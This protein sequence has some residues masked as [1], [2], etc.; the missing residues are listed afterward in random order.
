MFLLTSVLALGVIVSSTAVQAEDKDDKKASIKGVMKSAHGEAGIRAK[1]KKGVAAK[2]WDDVEA[3]AKDWV[4]QAEALGKL[5]PPKGE[6]ESWKKLTDAYEKN[7]K[8]VAA[9]ATKKDAKAVNTAMGKIGTSCG[10]CHKAHK[11]K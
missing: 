5:T 2:E 6:D 3:A 4:K 11:G 1:V 9:G 7:V 10:G 8:A